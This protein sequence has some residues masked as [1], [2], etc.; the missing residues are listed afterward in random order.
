MYFQLHCE[1]KTTQIKITENILHSKRKV[2]QSSFRNHS[3]PFYN[4]A[5]ADVQ[6]HFVKA[7]HYTFNILVNLLSTKECF[8]YRAA[9]NR[10]NMGDFRR[11]DEIAKS[12]DKISSKLPNSL[13]PAFLD[14]SGL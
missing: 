7:A 3:S 1:F 4:D 9:L 13:L 14:T 5:V 2:Q 11:Y 6:P 8:L 10:L 12:A